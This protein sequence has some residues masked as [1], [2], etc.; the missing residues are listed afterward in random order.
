MRIYLTGADGLLGSALTGALREN[1]R[2]AAWQVLGVSRGDF[3]IVDA[4]A[5]RASVMGFVPDVVI[6]TAAHAIV[7]DCEADPKLA[8]RVNVAGVCNVVDACRRVGSRLVYISTD[9][10]FDGADTPAGG[11]RE[12]DTPNPL[13]VYG[14]TKLAG[15]RTSALLPD[16]LTIRTSWLF[17]GTDERV[18]A[19][20]ATVRQ[21][22]RGERPQLIADQYS[23]PTYTEDLAQAIVFLLTRKRPVTGTIHV[24][25]MGT[26]SW[27]EV[28]AHVLTVLDPELAA[29]FE[30]V[31][32]ALDDCAYLGRR[33]RNSTLNTDRLAAL[34]HIMPDWRDAVR[35]FCGR[36]G[37]ADAGLLPVRAFD[38]RSS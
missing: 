37:R 34:G 22:E 27:Y 13:N 7:D 30:P 31:P 33:P 5:L 26:A 16:H 15:E 24:A 3:D 6:H 17:G 8:L 14:L 32:V 38:M 28:G 35:R 19:V 12:T 11:Y 25:N 36:F 2:T 21:A 18:D 4:A 29:T 10:V 1:P 23:L 20:L 9:Y